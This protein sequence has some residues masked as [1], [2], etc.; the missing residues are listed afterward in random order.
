MTITLAH[1]LVL[2]AILFAQNVMGRLMLIWSREQVVNSTVGVWDQFSTVP[3]AFITPTAPYYSAVNTDKCKVLYTK[4]FTVSSNNL[5]VTTGN[6]GQ[7]GKLVQCFVK[8]NRSFKFY[9]DGT[10]NSPQTGR[11]GNYFWILA[12]GQ[13]PAVDGV[14]GLIDPILI[15]VNHQYATFFKDG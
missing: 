4:R 1:Y 7:P 15:D 11:F 13:G 2:S 8:I 3:E 14:G 5:D 12:F 6:T 9:N 10:Q